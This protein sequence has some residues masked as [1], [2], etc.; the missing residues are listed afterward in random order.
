[1][2]NPGEEPFACS[3]KYNHSGLPHRARLLVVS[4][5][6]VLAALAFA[7]LNAF[8]GVC[9]VRGRT[10]FEPSRKAQHSA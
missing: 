4:L 7:R 8:R 9:C 10:V 2:F 6:V 5:D 3:T 1:M